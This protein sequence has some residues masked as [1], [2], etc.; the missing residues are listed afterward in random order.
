MTDA[1]KSHEYEMMGAQKI[2]EYVMT[3]GC[4]ENFDGCTEEN[5]CVQADGF[6]Q[7]S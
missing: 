7:N 4:T 1:Q 3:D 6:S 5:S 2:D